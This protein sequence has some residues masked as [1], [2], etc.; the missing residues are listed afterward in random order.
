MGY[1]HM[2]RSVWRQKGQTYPF[3]KISSCTN[4]F[5]N[6]DVM[7]YTACSCSFLVCTCTSVS[8]SV[9]PAAK[10]SYSFHDKTQHCHC[11]RDTRCYNVLL[12][13]E[14]VTYLRISGLSLYMCLYWLLCYDCG[15]CRLLAAAQ[16]PSTPDSAP[17]MRTADRILSRPAVSSRR[18]CGCKHWHSLRHVHTPRRVSNMFKHL[19]GDKYC[20]LYLTKMQWYLSNPSPEYIHLWGPHAPETCRGKPGHSRGPPPWSTHSRCLRRWGYPY[21]TPSSLQPWP[22]HLV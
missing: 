20:N 1:W 21:D 15:G 18:R 22:C 16:S 19:Y 17:R 9:T 11:H 2:L 4:L 10:S 13:T 14:D 6:E 8:A 12:Q 3:S 7:F 5:K